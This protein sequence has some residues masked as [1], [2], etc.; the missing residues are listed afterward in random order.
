MVCRTITMN[1][2]TNDDMKIR[3]EV[4]VKYYVADESG[5][6]YGGPFQTRQEAQ[7]CLKKWRQGNWSRKDYDSHLAVRL[8]P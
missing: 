8:R 2:T 3:R 1:K 7:E 4:D 6:I 5:W